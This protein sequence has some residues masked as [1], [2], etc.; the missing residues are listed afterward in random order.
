MDDYQVVSV[1]NSVENMPSSTDKADEV[2]LC[3]GSKEFE[4]QNRK[5]C[6]SLILF[7]T[8]S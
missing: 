7:R 1:D 3:Q 2:E 5:F 8:H 6:E 4:E